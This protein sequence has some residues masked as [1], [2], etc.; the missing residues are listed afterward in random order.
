[1]VM[2]HMNLKK[3]VLATAIASSFALISACSGGG[4]STSANNSTS[5]AITGFGSIHMN[6]S[7]II[8]D[9]AS[10]KSDG[11]VIVETDLSVGDVCDITLDGPIDAASATGTA[12]SVSCD[13][14]L[15]GYVMENNLDING[16]GNLV[17]MG[18]TV[19]VTSDTVTEDDLTLL[20]VND[21]IEVHGFSDGKGLIAATNIELK[22]A[23][24]DVELKGIVA[25]LDTANSTFTIGSL[26]IDYKA[27]TEVPP[28]MEN[29]LYVEAK[30]NDMLS[31]STM[32][33]Y[34]VELEDDGDMDIDGDEGDEIEV[35]GIVSNITDTSFD[36]N[37]S[38]VEFASIELDDDFDLASLTEGMII[39]VEGYIDANGNFVVE[40]IED[41]PEA[42]DEVKGHVVSWSDTSLTIT[43][44][45]AADI[46]FV[47]TADTRKKDERDEGQY[48][49]EHYFNMSSLA[50]G[51]F[52]EV[53]YYTAED[54]TNIA[55]EVERDDDPTIK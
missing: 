13:D 27:A 38:P 44:L 31:G 22:T 7:R 49:K 14:E 24:E 42:T 28:V 51:D 30:T 5:G 33:A 18:Q 4:S 52:V 2:K 32:F 46:S 40:E 48:I 47:I 19:K 11:K 39:T 17:V 23:D 20:A 50:E 35:T 34:K 29:G 10:M 8:T 41:E 12:I 37:G 45:G 25:N 16:V 43:E 3:T 9:A 1:M 53:K 15:E 6:S 26:T 36:F 21:I 54:S 55:T